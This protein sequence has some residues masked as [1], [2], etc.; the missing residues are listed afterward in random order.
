M[1]IERAMEILDPEHREHYESIEPVNE[2]CRMGRMALDVVK[3]IVLCK[4]C[5]HCFELDGK[6]PMTP[7]SGKGDGSFY[8]QEWDMDLYA[9]HYHADTYF[10]A[11]GKRRD[12]EHG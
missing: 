6:D 1:T 4:D 9:P 7:Y 5:E 10:C 8:C 2:A 12:E 3:R 11:N